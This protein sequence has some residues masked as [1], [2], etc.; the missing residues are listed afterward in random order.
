MGIIDKKT[1]TLLCPKYHVSD[2][3]NSIQKGSR[4]GADWGLFSESKLFALT[5]VFDDVLSPKITSAK[6]KNCGS[7]I[8]G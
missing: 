1:V 8:D 3:V 5:T 7:D 2:V 4:Y 6:C